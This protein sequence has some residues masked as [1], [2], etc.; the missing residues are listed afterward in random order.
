MKTF[1][2]FWIGGSVELIKGDDIADAFRKAGYGAG[3]VRSLDWYEEVK[4][5]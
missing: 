5:K 2:L 1:R 4:A 3:A